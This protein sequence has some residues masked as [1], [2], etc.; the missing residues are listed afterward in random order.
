MPL[1]RHIIPFP[2]NGRCLRRSGEAWQPTSIV[3]SVQCQTQHKFASSSDQ[4]CQSGMR[5]GQPP[6]AAAHLWIFMDRRCDTSSFIVLVPSSVT[7]AVE[8][9]PVIAEISYVCA[10][11]CIVT[12]F[13]ALVQVSPV[14]AC[15][16]DPVCFVANCVVTSICMDH[17]VPQCV[18]VVIV[19]LPT[20]GTHRR[21]GVCVCL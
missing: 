2:C 15:C 8:L 13:R 4:N 5:R 20:F 19:I 9:T 17:F 10:A 12:Q 21:Y 11:I 1:S 14:P 18:E 16:I 6:C 3:T 7:S